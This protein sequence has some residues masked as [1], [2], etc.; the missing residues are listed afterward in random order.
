[1]RISLRLMFSLVTLPGARPPGYL[2][3]PESVAEEPMFWRVSLRWG[4]L[5]LLLTCGWTTLGS[6][7][8]CTNFNP[9]LPHDC[10]CVRFCFGATS[11]CRLR[12]R[13]LLLYFFVRGN[14]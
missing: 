14:R 10:E 4:S 5:A 12:F 6:I 11:S 7:N 2:I 8:W 13:S 3:G 1:M 9:A